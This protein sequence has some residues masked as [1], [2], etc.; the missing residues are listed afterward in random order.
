MTG[1]LTQQA[2]QHAISLERIGHGGQG[3]AEQEGVAWVGLGFGLTSEPVSQPRGPELPWLDVPMCRRAA[4]DVTFVGGGRLS[5]LEG[6]WPPPI[7]RRWISHAS[8]SR[9][10][11]RHE[12]ETGRGGH[13]RLGLVSKN[14]HVFGFVNLTRAWQG[15]PPPVLTRTVKSNVAIPTLFACSWGL[16]PPLVT[17][18]AAEAIIV[19]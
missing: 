10:Q 14:A 18:S 3:R 7:G 8:R 15:P 1:L 4:D 9:I 16:E 19:W 11:I 5:R 17:L 12:T 2:G 13:A 6:G